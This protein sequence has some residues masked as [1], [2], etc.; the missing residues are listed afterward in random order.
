MKLLDLT[1][2][3]IV[4]RKRTV[5]Y[6]EHVFLSANK[7]LTACVF[8]DLT[9]VPGLLSNDMWQQWFDNSEGYNKN[10]RKSTV[11]TVNMSVLVC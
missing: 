3:L 9:V 7:Q 11:H 6:G 8:V 1:A 4:A 10:T 5:S 2:A